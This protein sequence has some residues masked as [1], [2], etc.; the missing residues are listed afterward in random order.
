MPEIVEV[1]YHTYSKLKIAEVVYFDG[2]GY[3]EVAHYE[4]PNVFIDKAKVGKIFQSYD[5]YLI[6]KAY[7]EG[8]E[9]GK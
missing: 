4:D 5:A 2:K 9:N 6:E 1:K 8:L 3:I 7:L